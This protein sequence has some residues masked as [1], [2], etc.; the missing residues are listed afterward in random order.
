MI[1]NDLHVSNL[2]TNMNIDTPYYHAARVKNLK[3]MEHP[4]EKRSSIKKN[5]VLQLAYLIMT[6]IIR[7]DD[8]NSY[9]MRFLLVCVQIFW[10]RWF[11]FDYSHRLHI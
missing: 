10:M 1:S 4:I 3:K 11:T 2:N 5:K 6:L 8:K 9:F 7:M